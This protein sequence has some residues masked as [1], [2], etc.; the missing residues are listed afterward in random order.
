MKDFSK[1]IR[2]V[3]PD[4]RKLF[5]LNQ[6]YNIGSKQIFSWDLQSLLFYKVCKA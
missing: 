3:S 5:L 4:S 1:K 6:N 2:I